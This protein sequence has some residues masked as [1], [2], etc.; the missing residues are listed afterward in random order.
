MWWKSHVDILYPSLVIQVGRWCL[1]QAYLLCIA[2]M[3]LVP[4]W[5]AM[6]HDIRTKLVCAVI[7][8][9]NTLN[10]GRIGV[11]LLMVASRHSGPAV[12][13]SRDNRSIIYSM[14]S[15]VAEKGQWCR[16]TRMCSGVAV[17]LRCCDNRS[18]ICISWAGSA[19]PVHL[20]SL[21]TNE[22]IPK[23]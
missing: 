17:G 5:F 11:I 10:F 14:C 19:V 1:Y 13:G 9:I 15:G 22:I 7:Q 23:N 8:W 2:M 18:I 21:R 12:L 4:R 6:Y 3:M 20:L 16:D